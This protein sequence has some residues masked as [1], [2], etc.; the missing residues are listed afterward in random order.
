[1]HMRDIPGI[2]K[3]ESLSRQMSSFERLLMYLLGIIL[4]ISSLAIV[5]ALSL[6]LMVDEP[7]PGGSLVEGEVGIPRFINPLLANSDA[8]R[9]LASLV[10]SGLMRAMPDG[11]LIPDLAESYQISADGTQYTFLLR[12]DAVFQDGKPVT[13]EDV[14]YTI[15]I[16]ENPDFKSTKRANWD[17]VK[18]E[19]IDERTVRF[20]IAKPYA[21]FL[22]NATLG[23]LPQHLWSTITADAFPFNQ[24]NTH[25]IGSGP[26]EISSV[27][28]DTTG[29][30]SEYLMKPFTHFTL[31]EAHISLIDMKL[32]ATEDAEIAAYQAGKIN[33]MA[34]V[35]ASRVSAL[36][37]PK[38]Q[39][40][41]TA[42]PR[43][44]AI[45]L[46]QSQAT[47]FLDTAVRKA[48]D[49]VLDKSAII[50]SALAG[51]GM[52]LDGP[53]PPGVMEN[54]ISSSVPPLSAA[55]STGL[56]A[57]GQK[58]LAA[59]GWT[60]SSTTGFFV[61]K[62]QTLAFSI[63]TADTPE[64]VAS[65]NAV[66]DQWKALGANVTVKV[67]SS[68]T[69]NTSVIRPRNYDSLLF[70]EVVGRTLDLFAFW[71]STQRNDPGLNL[72]LYTNAKADTL[73]SEARAEVDRKAREATYVSFA[74]I[75][76][77]DH[78]AVFLYAP[79]F[80]Y[81]IPAKLKGVALGALTTPSDRFLN[82]YQWH[83][84]TKNVWY[85]FSGH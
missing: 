64:L 44:F 68:G 55:S 22:E 79:D 49:A 16:A 37:I 46:N 47:V 8:D 7:A 14:L 75:V 69:I 6:M 11:T 70:G 9:D 5:H 10:Y 15:G 61:K 48:L 4:I 76:Q 67:F 72:A 45:F 57:N 38:D 40:L 83:I 13:A 62:G 54:G 19:K 3:L 84:E 74:K 35:T 56:I 65:A 25:P 33:A 53:I 17:G 77:D 63:S 51:F 28:T 26:Y 81:I 78:P 50:S 71:H 36:A 32:Y 42:L 31:G 12:S 29:T 60:L 27:K 18:V 73:L 58:I 82:V 23:I 52:P 39:V 30:P 59:D 2:R 1:M 41:T 43:V 80:I 66:A 85:I 21:P 20:T 24:L 34:G